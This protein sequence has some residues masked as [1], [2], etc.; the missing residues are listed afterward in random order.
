MARE[1]GHRDSAVSPA[2]GE[3]DPVHTLEGFG[4]HQRDG[5][6]ET[7]V[8]PGGL[9]CRRSCVF[10]GWRTSPWNVAVELAGASRRSAVD[11]V[12]AGFGSLDASI[13]VE[14]GLGLARV[15]DENFDVGW[16]TADLAGAPTGPWPALTGH[17]ECGEEAAITGKRDDRVEWPHSV[18]EHVGC[19]E[20]CDDD[21][22][23]RCDL[24]RCRG[25]D[26]SDRHL[27]IDFANSAHDLR[28][29]QRGR[30]IAARRR[31][32]RGRHGRRMGLP[33]ARR[34]RC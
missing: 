9:R 20:V 33:A 28:R 3:D 21:R 11:A 8:R 24:P 27:A 31:R 2:I 7:G 4:D 1:S 26:E 6:V 5:L 15:Q 10:Q 34:I 32:Q 12:G 14:V 19:A 16:N 29:R 23:G 22:I 25:A 17:L 18:A 13:A 30:V